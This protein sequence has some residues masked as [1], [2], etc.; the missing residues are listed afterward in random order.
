MM[1]SS[2]TR[3]TPRP[4]Q[5]SPIRMSPDD[6]SMY[7]G[8]HAPYSDDTQL[9]AEYE[10]PY[11]D[12]GSPYPDYA[13]MYPDDTSANQSQ[14]PLSPVVGVPRVPPPPSGRRARRRKNPT[15]RIMAF[16]SVVGLAAAGVYVADQRL[17]TSGDDASS[18]VLV[19]DTM[20]RTV[21]AG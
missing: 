9:Y 5:Q 11:A 8:H 7:P 2:P 21:P 20:S 19:A 12:Y 3:Y 17:G 16:A 14:V 10:S 15:R 6:G 4:I 1:P 13:A 18:T